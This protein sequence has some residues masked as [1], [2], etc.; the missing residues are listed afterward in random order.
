MINSTFFLTTI[1]FFRNEVQYAH[2][3]NI[4]LVLL[5]RELEHLGNGNAKL[6]DR[7]PR[8]EIADARLPHEFQ[9]FRLGKGQ[10]SKKPMYVIV[11]KTSVSGPVPS[12]PF[13][14]GRHA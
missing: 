7:D 1:I 3:C 11:L 6:A 12:V 10:P 5:S 14:R 4:Y 2:N 13:W 8:S 9:G